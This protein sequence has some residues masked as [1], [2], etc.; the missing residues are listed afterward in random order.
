MKQLSIV[1][2]KGKR[3]KRNPVKIVDIAQNRFE[4][5]HGEWCDSQYELISLMLPP[6]VKALYGEMQS[7]VETICG[8][9]YK[10]SEHSGSRWGTQ[11]GSI[12]LGNQKVAIENPVYEKFQSP[13]IFDKNV[14]VSGVK[15]VSQRDYKNGLPDIAASFGVT[16][17]AISRSWIKTTAKKL[18]EFMTRSL[19]DLD[20]TAVFLDGK[21]FQAKGV[22]IDMGLDTSG[23]KHVLG[24]YECSSENSGSCIELLNDLERRGLPCELGEF[25]MCKQI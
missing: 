19:K 6:A 13:D 23:K 14:F 24:V 17:S 22:L 18:E 7:A 2:N 1:G 21:R 20:L 16:K 4:V 15:K 9:R 3:K 5:K 8:S 10:H 11:A 25:T 12:Y